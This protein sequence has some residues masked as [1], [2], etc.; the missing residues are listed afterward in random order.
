MVLRTIVSEQQEEQTDVLSVLKAALGIR[1]KRKVILKSNDGE[2]LTLPVVPWKYQVTTGQLNK[3]YD[4][5]D[6]GE[7]LVF[8]NAK[9][10]KLKMSCFFPALHHGYPFITGDRLDPAA[11][12][13]RITKWKEAKQPVRVIITDSPVNLMMAIMEFDFKEK[14]GTRDIDY[15]LSFTEYKDLNVPPANNEK[16]V[17]TQTFLR[18][19]PD[20][21]ESIWK[22]PEKFMKVTQ[23]VIE[24]YKRLGGR[25]YGFDKFLTDNNIG[26][27]DAND[28]DQQIRDGTIILH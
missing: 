13:D 1:E 22:S 16:Q 25:T 2:T 26:H 24:I 15:S 3:V 14:D 11:C 28:I 5:L 17:D 27:F 8:G 10:K 7:A 21:E 23:D 4:I 20:E 18:E 19:R 9:L 6:F 12:V